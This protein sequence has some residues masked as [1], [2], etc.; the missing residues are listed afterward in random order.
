MLGEGSPSIGGSAGYTTAYWF[1][2]APVN[3]RGAW[4]GDF[5]LSVPTKDGGNLSLSTWVNMD[6]SNSTGDAFSNEGNGG[7]LTEVDYVIDYSRTVGDVSLNLGFADYSFPNG[8][9]S[10]TNEL[11]AG[12]ST[13]YW[14]FTQSLSVYYD[15][16]LL[17]DFYVSLGA[18][19]GFTLNEKLSLNLALQAGYMGEDQTAFYFG[20]NE[21]ALSD[22]VGS[23]TLNYTLDDNTSLFFSANGVTT[24]DSDLEDALDA[25]GVDDSGIW[26]ML[27][28]SWS[29]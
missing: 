6:A 2:G 9:G 11:Y 3:T 15:I 27:G 25:S 7:K 12:A 19:R 10:S 4:Q 28:S 29:L 21:T 17:E 24:L 22:L 1:R 8:V 14:G 16:D 26:F 13:N 5:G 23:A 20:A 18:S